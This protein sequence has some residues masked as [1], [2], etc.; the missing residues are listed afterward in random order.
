VPGESTTWVVFVHGRNA[1]RR[2]ALRALATVHEAGLPGLVI[3]Y[4]NDPDAPPGDGDGHFRYG[5]TEWRDLESGVAWALGNGARQVVLT[6]YSMG[7]AICL[8]FMRHSALAERVAG[9][10]LDAPM[11]SFEAAVDF[12]ADERGIP[13]FLTSVAKR[14]ADWRFGIPWDDLDYRDEARELTVPVLLF[15][16]DEDGTTPIAESD[17][18]AAARPDIVTY[19]RVPG[20]G[21]VQAWNVDPAGYA[22]AL[23]DF[24]TRVAN[25]TSP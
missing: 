6:G 23:Q 21:H 3:S 14:I 10:I 4:R 18:L 15:H 24:L 9:L 17:A 12:E 16:G 5:E 25:P 22:Q 20:A 1:P 2:E 13:G 8:S 7:G 11:L 19:L